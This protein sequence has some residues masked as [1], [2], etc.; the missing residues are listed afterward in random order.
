MPLLYLKLLFTP[1]LMLSISLAARRW[2]GLLGG[3]L[4]GLPITS[5]GVMLFLTLEQG[6]GFALNAVPGAL[7]GLVAVLAAYLAYFELTRQRSAWVGGLGALGCYAVTATV[8]SQGGPWLLYV[9]AALLLITGLV[10]STGREPAPPLSRH[11]RS[12]AWVIPLRMLAATLLLLVVT[13]SAHWLGP[14]VSGMLAPVP[15]IAWPLTV[16]SHIQ[17]GRGELAAVVRGDAIGAVGV[18]AF[19]LL[20]RTVLG[21]WGVALTFLGAVSLAVAVTLGLARLLNRPATAS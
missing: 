8:F 10:K 11:L 14:R 9:A 13:A 17:G 7:A 4:S 15:V 5:A 16:F 20:L 12:P 19:Y 1:L 2:G 3:L 18:L 21:E 6:Q